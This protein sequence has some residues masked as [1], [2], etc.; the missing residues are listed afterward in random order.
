MDS[1]QIVKFIV[2]AVSIL[3]YT[4]SEILVIPIGNFTIKI[5]KLVAIM[6]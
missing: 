2:K 5:K 3:L 4:N 6:R 1:K